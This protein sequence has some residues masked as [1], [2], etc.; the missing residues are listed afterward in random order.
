MYKS[1][2]CKKCGYH[3]SEKARFC[4]NCGNSFEEQKPDQPSQTKEWFQRVKLHARSSRLTLTTV[5]KRSPIL[6]VSFLTLSVI[7]A[8]F[9]L[10]T[11]LNAYVAPL[12]ISNITIAV[13]AINFSFLEYQLFPYRALLRS[14]PPS[15]VFL[16]ALILLSTL[17]VFGTVTGNVL[18]P[19]AALVFLPLVACGGL[20]LGKIARY[21]GSPSTMLEK[22]ASEIPLRDFLKRYIPIIE[23]YQQEFQDIDIED[24]P[25]RGGGWHQQ[26]PFLSPSVKIKESPDM[27]D[28]FHFL[29]NLG[30]VTIENHDIHTFE[31]VIERA[32]E[33]IELITELGYPTLEEQQAN[34]EFIEYRTSWRLIEILR[35]TILNLG[36]ATI[37]PEVSDLFATQFMNICG[38]YI[39]KEADKVQSAYD[40][41]NGTLMTFWSE[42]GIVFVMF[43]MDIMA[44]IAEDLLHHGNNQASLIPI[45]IARGAGEKGAR[46]RGMPERGWSLSFSDFVKAR[47]K[48][49]IRIPDPQ[50]VY[51]CLNALKELSIVALQAQNSF[52]SDSSLQGIVQLGRES[53]SYDLRTGYGVGQSLYDSARTSL[54]TVA[55]TSRKQLLDFRETPQQNMFGDFVKKALSRLNGVKYTTLVTRENG[56]LVARFERSAAPYQE[57]YWE[58]IDNRECLADYQ[59]PDFVKDMSLQSG[60]AAE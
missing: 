37:R 48:A 42:A 56:E 10:N 34:K 19:V 8:I 55:A 26:L 41:K 30:I 39:L 2:F 46:M 58:G 25:L 50:Y 47:G 51:Q 24:Q 43:L 29:V 31:Q 12:L 49:A 59:D 32:L 3:S 38:S 27:R 22:E 5:G 52:L 28:P 6:I 4:S 7:L 45:F 20:L 14:A 18:S 35:I 13:F 11:S 21:E 40:A 23:A 53:R 44:T 17:F 57:R 36:L 1:R 33:A 60:V 15:Q 16:S 9:G 54:D